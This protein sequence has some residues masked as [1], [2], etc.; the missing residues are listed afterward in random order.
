MGKGETPAYRL[1]PAASFPFLTPAFDLVCAVM[2]LGAP[3]ASWPWPPGE[4]WGATG[5]IP[6]ASSAVC[7][8]SIGNRHG[9]QSMPG[10]RQPWAPA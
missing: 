5:A 4:S 8:G 6:I 9:Y 3:T 7:G 10:P 2:G 1:I